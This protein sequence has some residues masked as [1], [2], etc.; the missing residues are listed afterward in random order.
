M[1]WWLYQDRMKQIT[2]LLTWDQTTKSLANMMKD[3][4][5]NLHTTN[6]YGVP[7]KESLK[8]FVS[9]FLVNIL[10]TLDNIFWSLL[11]RKVGPNLPW[12]LQ[13]ELSPFCTSVRPPVSTM[14]CFF[15]CFL[16]LCFCDFDKL[17]QGLF[18]SLSGAFKKKEKVFVKLGRKI[19]IHSKVCGRKESLPQKNSAPV[20]GITLSGP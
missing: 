18:S 20:V 17:S 5:W 2:R 3:R 19:N 13:W 7:I 4:G 14:R 9:M 1:I 6:P 10:A 11:P 12:H 8:I 16:Y 15:C